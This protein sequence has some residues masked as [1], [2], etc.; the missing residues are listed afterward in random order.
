MIEKLRELNEE[1]LTA[2]GPKFDL[3]KVLL[4][5]RQI[6]LRLMG[7]ATMRFPEAE[8]PAMEMAEGP[9]KPLDDF[10]LGVVADLYRELA[11]TAFDV[12]DLCVHATFGPYL[13]TWSPLGISALYGVV[14]NCVTIFE[15][16]WKDLD[17]TPTIMLH[18]KERP[19]A[20]MGREQT[21]F[22]LESLSPAPYGT[23]IDF[24]TDEVDADTVIIRFP[25]D[26]FGAG[27][28]PLRICRYMT[29]DVELV[30]DPEEAP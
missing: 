30:F 27:R 15:E 28:G 16:D 18:S 8:Q 21:R 29:L 26:A 23:E 7:R 24:I 14:G 22:L 5:G 11:R 4:T 17:P 9:P 3:D 12:C 6:L 13:A 10:A 19:F 1:T 20:P 25:H 2:I